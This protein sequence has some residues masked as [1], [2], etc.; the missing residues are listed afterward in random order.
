MHLTK[1]EKEEEEIE[2]CQVNSCEHQKKFTQIY[3]LAPKLEIPLG[4]QVFKHQ[5]TFH[6]KNIWD[7]WSK[8]LQHIVVPTEKKNKK[9]ENLKQFC[10]RNKTK[11]NNKK[12]YETIE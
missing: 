9:K 3:I 7:K 10:R 2:L 6:K 1:E 12:T 8:T 4:Y 11:K 5:F